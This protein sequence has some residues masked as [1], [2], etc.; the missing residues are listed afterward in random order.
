MNKSE[1][2]NNKPDLLV[3]GFALL[4][5]GILLTTILDSNRIIQV[6]GLVLIIVSS[7]V[8]GASINSQVKSKK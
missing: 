7:A 3:V 1:R 8:F 6:I 4:L 2:K 5:P